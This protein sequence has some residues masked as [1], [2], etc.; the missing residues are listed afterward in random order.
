MRPANLSVDDYQQVLGSIGYI[1]S[2]LEDAEELIKKLNHLKI[3][4]EK[5]FESWRSQLE[6]VQRKLAYVEDVIF[7]AG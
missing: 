1:R 4:E 3:A 7:A 6:D 5:E 2:K